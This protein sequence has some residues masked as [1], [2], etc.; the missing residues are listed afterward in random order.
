MAD[1]VSVLDQLGPDFELIISSVQLFVEKS[2]RNLRLLG[3]C[4]LQR[5]SP[6]QHVLIDA[7]PLDWVA[8]P[9][10]TQVSPCG[11]GPDPNR[12]VQ[13]YVQHEA[14]LGEALQE[15]TRSSR[16]Q[17]I[18]E[19]MVDVSPQCKIPRGDGDERAES[20]ARKPSARVVR[21]PSMHALRLPYEPSK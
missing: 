4:H 1:Q 11:C 5:E 7:D 8:A 13:G 14:C 20:G 16:T 18:G 3:Q 15:D 12:L 10:T 19:P 21:A 2:Y 6:S 9:I 17:G